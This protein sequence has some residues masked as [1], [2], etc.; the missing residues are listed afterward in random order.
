MDY[1]FDEHLKICQQCREHP[2][3]TCAEGWSLL[4]RIVASPLPR[5]TTLAPDKGQAAVV[6]DNQVFAPCG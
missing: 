6:K 3:E 1:L 2:L 4:T 5:P